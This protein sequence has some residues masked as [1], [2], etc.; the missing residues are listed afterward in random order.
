MNREKYQHFIECSNLG[1]WEWNVQTGE[2]IFNAR[3]AEIIGYTL[4]E[5]EPIDINT[6]IRLAHPEDLN[7][8][9]AVLQDHFAGQTPFYDIDARM[10]HKSGH[11]VWVHDRGR[12]VEWDEK[13]R[14]TWM[15]GTH[16]E[17]TEK[18]ADAYNQLKTSWL[19]REQHL[20]LIRQVN[21]STD[22]FLNQTLNLALATTGSEHGYIFLYDQAR[23][24]FNSYTWSETVPVEN[25]PSHMDHPHHLEDVGLL[26]ESI[27]QKAP[28]VVNDYPQYQGPQKGL[29][30]GHIRVRNFLSIPVLSEGQVVAVVGLC[31]KPSDFTREDIVALE[32]LMNTV[33]PMVELRHQQ[34]LLRD[35]EERFRQLFE[36]SMDAIL[37][38]GPEGVIL[39]ANPAA[40][41]LLGLA[42]EDLA[43]GFKRGLLVDRT[44]PRLP[45]ATEEFQRTGH[46]Q[47]EINFKGRGGRIFPADISLSRYLDMQGQEKSSLILRDKSKEYELE[48]QIEGFLKIN[49]DMLCVATMRGE[50]IKVNKRFEEVLGYAAGELVGVNFYTLIHPEDIEP[51][52]QAMQ[53]LANGESVH[54]FI[55]RYRTRNGLYLDLEWQ[56][57]PGAGNTVYASARDVTEKRQREEKLRQAAMLDEL[58]GLY[59]RHYF[60]SIIGEQMSHADRF[61]EQISLILLDLDHFK[62]V[63]DTWGHPTGDELLKRTA[64]TI[65]QSIRE[66]DILVR[67]GGEEFAVLL[68][69]TDLQGAQIAAEK[70]RAAIEAH[71]F[72]E[73]G[74]RTASLGAGERHKAES[75]RHWYRRVDDALYQAKQRGRN[76]VYA[77]DGLERLDPMALQLDWC[78]DWESGEST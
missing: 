50:L 22:D 63:N 67:F 64:R 3:W 32:L 55:N 48:K 45:A 58:T 77:S 70:I 36:T 10:Q 75:F 14:P 39:S 30:D 41:H 43:A 31:N 60:E 46:Y 34:Q 25:R 35:S 49:M 33:W 11:W 44:D 47:G 53:V 29:P 51:T 20:D 23:S 16:S 56:A 42:P 7:R 19:N 72:P 54:A 62:T 38:S 21:L 13:G 61:N 18:I 74:I 78:T 15:Y 1:T 69:Q 68:P 8:S 9:M 2:T 40:M 73:I 66:S 12:V 65:R 59:N 76:Q 71:S 17:I 6:W 57:E 26:G 4:A 5:L 27:R 28:L 37:I 52:R 24:S